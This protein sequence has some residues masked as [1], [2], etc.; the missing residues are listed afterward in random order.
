MTCGKYTKKSCAIASNCYHFRDNH[1]P[2]IADA[3]SEASYIMAEHGELFK[4]KILVLVEPLTCMTRLCPL[5]VHKHG[6]IVHNRF[7]T[8]NCWRAVHYDISLQWTL[9]QWY[10][11][12]IYRLLCEISLQRSLARTISRRDIAKIVPI[13]RWFIVFT[14]VDPCNVSLI[15]RR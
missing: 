8:I 12:V 15:Y 9:L 10:I 3:L 4:S 7:I 6:F 2:T 5:H 14:F 1:R 11:V 13:S